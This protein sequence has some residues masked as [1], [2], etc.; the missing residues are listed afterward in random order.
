MPHENNDKK[1]NICIRQYYIHVYKT[2]FQCIVAINTY[3]VKSLY[4]SNFIAVLSD[5]QSY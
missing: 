5:V 2:S 4:Q 1:I 3:V